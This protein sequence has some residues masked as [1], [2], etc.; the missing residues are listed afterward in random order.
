[1][2][3][4]INENIK[5]L[6]R[7]KNITQEKLAEHLNIST[8]AVSK[9]ERSEAYPDITMILPIASYFNV[10][11]DELLGL[12]T[13]K[14]EAKINE[15][16][17]EYASLKN[18]GKWVEPTELITE[19]HKEFPN[20][21]RITI[22]YLYD[23][24]GSCAD[25]TVDV[26]LSCADELTYQC[27][28]II[29]ECTVDEIRN[30]AIDILA[31]VEK[32]KGNIDKAIE[33]LGHFPDW[34]G[35][36][37]YQ[38]CEQLFDEKTPEWWHYINF[39]FFA[40][41][42]FALNKLDKIIWF[43]DVDFDEKIKFGNMTAEYLIKLLDDTNYEMLKYFIFRTYEGLGLKYNTQGKSDKAIEYIDI[44]LEY[45][46]KFDE[47][48]VS[49][50]QIANTDSKFKH[51]I[52]TYWGYWKENLIMRLL[53]FYDNSPQFAIL[54]VDERFIKM[55]EKYRSFAKGII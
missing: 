32:A 14:N 46:V 48:I 40:L 21:F 6:R 4:Y 16:L 10:S 15:Y 53:K 11:T 49:N 36:T 28:R 8:Q 33:L 1:M 23:I 54:R 45:A 34:F 44:A 41:S 29:A 30:G 19:A 51:D 38:K 5:R 39:N 18:Q 26:V 2:N 3:I 27:N 35:C 47:F 24:I 55:I 37:K 7:E 17:A 50:R 52:I 31:K 22:R 9:W 43:S 20:D 42:D 25:N 13:A 12:D